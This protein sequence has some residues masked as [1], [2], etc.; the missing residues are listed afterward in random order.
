[1]RAEDATVDVRLVDD[2]VPEVREDV[3][4]PVVMRQQPDVD[5]VRVRED[6]VRGA[7]DL[8]AVLDRRVAVVDRRPQR[9]Q[10]MARQRAELVL[11]ERLRRVEIERAVPRVARQLVE[12]GQVERERLAGSG[13]GRDDDMLAAL[14]GRGCGAALPR[15]LLAAVGQLLGAVQQL[16]R[17]R[18]DRHPS[19]VLTTSAAAGLGRRPAH[20]AH[21]TLHGGHH[22]LSR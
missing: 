16:D 21:P 12:H 4:P 8:A 6:Q 1:M 18:G 9:A 3:R 5:H 20:G 2:D 11:R 15:R 13:A 10:A 14:V 7:A 17:K 22:P 19:I